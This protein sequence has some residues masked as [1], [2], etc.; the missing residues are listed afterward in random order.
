[1]GPASR[2][3]HYDELRQD[4]EWDKRIEWQEYLESLDPDE[5]EETVIPERETPKREI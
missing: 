1:M 3:R 4:A 5:A 2:S